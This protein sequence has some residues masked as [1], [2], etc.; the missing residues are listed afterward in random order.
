MSNPRTRLVRI[1]GGVFRI[2]SDEL[3][4]PHPDGY[5][6]AYGPEYGDSCGAEEPDWPGMAGCA[7]C[8]LPP[9]STDPRHGVMHIAHNGDD[10]VIAIWGETVMT[11]NAIWPER[12]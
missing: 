10:Q 7:V 2:L 1:N 4:D 8:T 5:G 3:P 9:H 11:D 6:P 12:T